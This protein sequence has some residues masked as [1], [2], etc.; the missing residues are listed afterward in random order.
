MTSF[1]QLQLNV[2]NA[3]SGKPGK[4]SDKY[5]FISTQTFVNDMQALGYELKAM[6]TPR[7]GLGKHMLSFGHPA[8]PK[9]D[10]LGGLEVRVNVENSHDGTSAFTLTL[11]I[12]R[13]VCSNGLMVGSTF[14]GAKVRHVGYAQAKVYAALQEVLPQ[15]PKVLEFALAAS[16]V[17]L[18]AEQA[19][20]FAE[21]AMRLRVEDNARFAPNLTRALRSEDV[22]PTL[23]NV[24]NRIQE[25]LLKGNYVY[26]NSSGHTRYAKKLTRVAEVSRVNRA[27]WDLANEY[28]T[29]NSIIAA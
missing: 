2:L 7:K 24:F 26:E 1:N 3:T 9:I 19:F 18:S 20:N 16:Q 4:V 27:L 25:N 29:Q 12:Y 6:S 14:I 5:T 10:A 28:L 23:W 11:G 17:T 13:Q 15:A 21:R 8:L 22:A